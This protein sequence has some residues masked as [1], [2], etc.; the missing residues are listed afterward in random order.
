MVALISRVL[1]VLAGLLFL[2][3]FSTT[4]ARAE[5]SPRIC[6]GTNIQ[7]GVAIA[8]W[9]SS[10]PGL[11]SQGWFTIGPGE[12]RSLFGEDTY[13]AH[14]YYFA[15]NEYDAQHPELSRA[16]STGAADGTGWCIADGQRF[17]FQDADNCSAPYL[18]RGFLHI[19][20]VM[21]NGEYAD[22]DVTLTWENARAGS[23]TW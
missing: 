9:G 16:W 12:C 10:S 8:W 1:R 17:E 11:H 2:A 7:V 3:M 15:Y 20:S 5:G 4:L 21:V 6:N 23:L 18:R 22:P 19:D 14:R 13:T